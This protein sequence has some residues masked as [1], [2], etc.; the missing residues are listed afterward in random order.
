[1]KYGFPVF[2]VLL[3]ILYSCSSPRF[4]ARSAKGLTRDPVLKNAHVGIVLYDAATKRNIY[5]YQPDK[6]FIPAS[7][8]KIFTLYAA[9]K[10]LGDSLPG[11]RFRE[12][13]DSFFIRPTA[14]PT[15]LHPDFP[16]QPVVSRL[17]KITKPVVLELN[18]DSISPYGKGWS[19]DD[20]NSSYMAE[21]NALPVY[22]N[23]ISWIQSAQSHE[24]QELQ[25]PVQ[26]F[27]FSEPDVNWKVRFIEDTSNKTFRVSRRKDENYFEVYQGNESLS[28][29]HVPFITYGVQSALDLLKDTVH[30]DIVTVERNASD[31]YGIIYSQRSDSLYRQMMH[32]SD[33]FF[34]EQLLL[35]AAN[36]RFG[37]MDEEKMI[38]HLLDSALKN[39]PQ[40]PRWVDG[41]GLSRYNLFTPAAFVWILNHM[42]ETFGFDRM[43][44][45]FAGA[46]QGT[47][48]GYYSGNE[49]QIFAKTGTLS[50]NVALSGLMITKKKRLLVFSILVN[51]HQS[52]AS[53]VRRKIESFLKNIL[54][55]Y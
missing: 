23:V 14:D 47:L 42:Q 9:L 29:Q 34:A 26:T 12:T 11:L 35:M 1:M 28:V 44:S 5:G 27:V 10:Y 7:N 19:W 48:E 25:G 46:N 55:K 15:L 24:Q 30:Q 18:K 33:N 38:H 16:V 52:S 54:E 31:S 49:G 43:K 4:I 8:A 32:N 53:D 41:S 3:F 40:R 13:A 45:I 39:L 50:A 37:T 51:N 6:Y 17:Q 2:S 20:F 21:R 22:G 36:E